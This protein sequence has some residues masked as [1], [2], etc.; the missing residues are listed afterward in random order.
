MDWRRV[1]TILILFMLAVNFA[2]LLLWGTRLYAAN[3][4]RAK[5]DEALLSLLWEQG[6]TAELGVLPDETVMAYTLEIPRDPE[7]ERSLVE[8]LLGACEAENTGG[9]R[10]AYVSENGEAIFDTGGDLRIR[11]NEPLPFGEKQ[12]ALEAASALLNRWGGQSEPEPRGGGVSVTQRISGLPLWNGEM[13]LSQSG[14][15]FTELSGRWVLGAPSAVL[16][17]PGHSAGFCLLRFGSNREHTVLAVELGYASA[18]V[19]PEIVR[20]TPVWR[21]TMED[22]VHFINAVTAGEIDI[23]PEFFISP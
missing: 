21:V 23:G 1:K 11:P 4:A 22:G 17:Q 5:G 2:L 20:L 10:I 13:R 12:D 6:L 19:S 7:L 16:S 9:N 3:S 18:A 14:R 15:G 8:E